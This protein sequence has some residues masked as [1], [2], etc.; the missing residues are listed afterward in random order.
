MDNVIFS[1][2]SPLGRD[3]VKRELVALVLRYRA[4]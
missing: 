2:E 4:A 3:A 1:T